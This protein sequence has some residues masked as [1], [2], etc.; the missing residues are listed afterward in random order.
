MKYLKKLTK[1][2]FPIILAYLIIGGSAL[3]ITS[4]YSL[5]ASTDPTIFVNQK[6]PY[7][8]LVVYLIIVLILKKKNYQ[9]EPQ[10][11]L[12]YY[13]PL[14]YLGLSLSCFLN[15]LIFKIS[16]PTTK[17]TTSLITSI[18]SS[19]L[20]GP[21]LEEYLFRYY[22][23]NDLKKYNSP[24]KALVLNCLLFAIVHSNLISILYALILGLF[25]NLTYYKYKSIQAPLLIHMSAN[26]ISIFLNQYNNSILILSSLGLLLSSTII[27]QTNKTIFKT[28]DL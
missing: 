23:V 10:L 1:S 19:A 16:P 4:V 27:F 6:L 24:F 28:P 7:Y 26:L 5:I 21:I 11:K 12:K 15:M 3:I 13:F 8:M 14:I 9:K 18:I 20:A 25:L 22:L 2:L 17:V